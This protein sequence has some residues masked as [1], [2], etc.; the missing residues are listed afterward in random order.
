MCFLSNIRKYHD[1][2][3]YVIII[4]D[5]ICFLFLSNENRHDNFPLWFRLNQKKKPCFKRKCF[6]CNAWSN[7][8]VSSSDPIFEKRNKKMSFACAFLEIYGFDLFLMVIFCRILT[9]SAELG[10]ALDCLL[11]VIPT[12]EEVSC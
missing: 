6:H 3:I 9:I 10:T 1:K 8:H 12:L 2:W 11:D 5:L 7:G 4:H